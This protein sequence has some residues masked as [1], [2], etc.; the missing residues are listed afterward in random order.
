MYL[1]FAMELDLSLRRVFHS[2]QTITE[3]CEKD[4]VWGSASAG[5]PTLFKTRN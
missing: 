4:P 2:L 5:C 3:V 1:S